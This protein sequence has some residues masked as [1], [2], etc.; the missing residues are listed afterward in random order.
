MSWAGIWTFG[1]SWF[2]PI[3][4]CSAVGRSQKGCALY[5]YLRRRCGQLLRR[6]GL[7][8]SSIAWRR[9]GLNLHS[10]CNIW[11]SCA[12]TGAGADRVF[13]WRSRRSCWRLKI[14]WSRIPRLLPPGL[15]SA[16]KS[17]TQHC[18]SA[19]KPTWKRC[20]VSRRCHKGR[21][22][23]CSRT[24]SFS[25]PEGWNTQDAFRPEKG[26]WRLRL[27]PGRAR[28]LWLASSR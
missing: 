8:V 11:M 16:R 10:A 15:L 24:R 27:A 19:S 14:I 13:R 6:L 3:R 7:S 12:L 5:L 18:W 26:R 25:C 23:T 21:C 28:A 17:T 20:C 22:R 4:R 9:C 1:R 2:S